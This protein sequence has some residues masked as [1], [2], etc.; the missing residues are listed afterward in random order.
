MQFSAMTGPGVAALLVGWTALSGLSICWAAD[1]H[2][3]DERLLVGP[4]DFAPVLA[5]EPG[6]PRL[7]IGAFKLDRTPVTNEQ[8]LKF[9]QSHP[10]WRRDRV[11]SLFADSGYLSHWAAPEELGSGVLRQQPVTRVSWYAAR[12]YCQAA[13][14][15]LPGWYEWELAAAADEESIDA[16]SNSS[17]R[18]RILDWYAQ[19]G[20]RPLP[21]VGSSAA[22][23]YG[24]QDLHGLIWEWVEDFSSLMVSGDSRTQ[25][26]PDRLA[27]CGA[28]A[29]GAQDR[30]NYPILMRIAFLSAL[31]ARST[32]RIL[33]FRCAEAQTTPRSS[34]IQQ[35][36]QQ[37]RTVALIPGDS[38]YQLQMSL[39]TAEGMAIELASLRGRPLLVTLFY[40]HCSSVC[41][42]LTAQ[43]QSMERQ[44]S[45]Q[46]R[47]NLT[48]LMVSLDSARDT[49]AILSSFKQEHRIDDPRWVVA[50]A[51]AADVR[52]LAAAL[53]VRYRELPDQSFNHSAV[54]ALADRDGV[55]R[56]RVAGVQAVD[57]QILQTLRA[58]ATSGGANPP[59]DE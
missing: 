33:G 18:A 19:P 38:L 14:G 26:D 13:G 47:S 7:H 54:I 35:P 43:L 58:I 50:R 9:V 11:P 55:I 15:R 45:P 16:R 20:G 29:L 39:Q 36:V 48:V 34:D 37:A 44:L 5:P 49:P 52:V 2:T 23:V 21:E 4:A 17:W 1:G 53:G 12:A 46:A 59:A 10:A 28:G 42:L 6:Q 41:P 32:G 22:N 31:E 51:S 56:A 8:F 27:Y 30:E 25:G 40:A 57:K 24:I 3:V